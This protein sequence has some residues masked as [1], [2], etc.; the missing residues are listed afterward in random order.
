MARPWSEVKAEA[1]KIRAEQ[2]RLKPVDDFLARAE[3][4]LGEPMLPH[5]E[6]I[7]SMLIPTSPAERKRFPSPELH[8]GRWNVRAGKTILTGLSEPRY[9][10]DFED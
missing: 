7:V 2:G 5:Q 9:L 4:L 3:E 1:A 8:V 10:E 6:Q